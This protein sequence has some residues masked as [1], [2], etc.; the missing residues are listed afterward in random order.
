MGNVP[1]NRVSPRVAVCLPT[2]GRDV[3]GLDRCV[4]SLADQVRGEEL[5]IFLIDNSMYGIPQLAGVTH[6]LHFGVNMGFVGAMELVR[7]ST[8]AEFLWAIQDD[9]EALDGCL[10]ALLEQ[11]ESSRELGALTPIVDRGNGFVS[12]HR[13]G[14]RVAKPAPASPWDLWPSDPIW[15]QDVPVDLN[16]GFV[17]SSGTLYRQRALEEIG[18]F[19]QELYPLTHVDVDTGLRLTACGWSSSVCSQARIHH[20]KSGSTTHALFRVT[21]R[22]NLPLIKGDA[23]RETPKV[24]LDLNEWRPLVERMSHLFY[25]VAMEYEQDLVNQRAAAQREI[26]TYRKSLSWR[27]TAPARA[28]SRFG[29]KLVALAMGV[30]GSQ[31]LGTSS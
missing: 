11:M 7:N 4:R 19:R 25:L 18:G 9:T 28:L 23:Q 16:L 2:L 31:G 20:S 29:R 13:G 30:R 26:D 15:I 17:F 27:L 21:S 22:L 14:F 3:D 12:D 8:K 24:H 5:E 1:T 6:H 10:G